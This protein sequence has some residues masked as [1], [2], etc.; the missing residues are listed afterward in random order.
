MMKTCWHCFY[1]R[2]GGICF[3]AKCAWYETKGEDPKDIPPKIVDIGC[4]FY[5]KKEEEN[6]EN[7][8]EWKQDSIF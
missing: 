4:K 3:P 6:K 7:G 8:K 1:I 2:L 5:K